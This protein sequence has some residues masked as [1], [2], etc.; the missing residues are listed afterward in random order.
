MGCVPGDGIFVDHRDTGQ[1]LNNQRSN[2]RVATRAENNRNQRLRRDSGTGCKCVRLHKRTG[3][4]EAY[5][6]VDGKLK[7][8][9]YRDTPEEAGLLVLEAAVQNYGE[10]A[11]V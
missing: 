6:K 11:R 7:S 1:T 10:F 5:L 8:F 9:G 3:K 2:L 4:Y